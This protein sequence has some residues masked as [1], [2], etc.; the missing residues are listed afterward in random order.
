MNLGCD[1]LRFQWQNVKPKSRWN[2]PSATR[3]TEG[4]YP[5]GTQMTWIFLK[6]KTSK[7]GLNSFQPKT[8]G[9][10]PLGF[11]CLRYVYLFFSNF[12]IPKGH[13]ISS[14]PGGVFTS[15]GCFFFLEELRS[16][17]YKGTPEVNHWKKNGG[18]FWMMINLSL[19]KWWLDF[20]HICQTRHTTMRLAFNS[21]YCGWREIDAF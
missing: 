3:I 13:S 7:Q 14:H 20:Q 21:G 9:A 4:L 12:R 6:V 1:L 18:S 10:C 5:P 11:R 8:A 16:H 17:G 2:F 15:P 19:Q